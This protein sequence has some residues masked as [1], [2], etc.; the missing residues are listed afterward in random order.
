M[1]KRQATLTHERLIELLMYEEDT[2][3]F[4]WRVDRHGGMKAGDIAGC[5]HSRSKYDRWQIVIDGVHHKAHRLAWFY[6]HG[7]WPIG[8]ID[9]VNRD[10]MDNRISNLRDSTVGQNC[11]NSVHPKGKTKFRGVTYFAN[12]YM[13]QI[14]H[15]GK[16]VYLGRFTTAEEAHAAW[17]EAAKRLRGEFAHTG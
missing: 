15:K 12:G 4:R 11:A 10:A 7:R 9:H 1:T 14:S 2:G 6:V 16:S 8:C 5:L 3:H 13:A 17:C